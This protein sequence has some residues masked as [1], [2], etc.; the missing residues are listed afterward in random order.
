MITSHLLYKFYYF[1]QFEYELDDLQKKI[2]L[3]KGT[4]GI[5][6]AARDLNT[7]VRIAVK[8][9]P[10]KNLGYLLF[11]VDYLVFILI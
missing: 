6:Y 2:V 1:L 9:I 11:L 7:Q 8:E 3:G 4:Y 5:V 10:E